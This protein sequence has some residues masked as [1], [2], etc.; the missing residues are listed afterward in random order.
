MHKKSASISGI[1]APTLVIAEF[2]GQIYIDTLN[3]KYYIARSLEVGDWVELVIAG[4]F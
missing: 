3:Q 2:I 1:I 4:L